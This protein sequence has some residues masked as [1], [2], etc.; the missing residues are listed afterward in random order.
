ML[1]S[2]ILGQEKAKK[3]LK[4]VMAREKMPHAYLFT[5]IPGIGKTSMALALALAL[6]C[7]TPVNG[8]GCGQCIPCRQML[9][10]NFPDFLSIKPE[11]QHIK[12]DQIR[13]LNRS[14]GFP[15]VSGGYRMCVIYQ[16]ETMTIEAANSFLKTLE[17]P[18]PGNILILNA[19][20]PLGLLPTIVSRCQ[21]V[22]FQPLPVQDITDWLVKERDLNEETAQVLAR[23][24]AGSLGRALKMCDSGFFDKREEWLARVI[25]LPALSRDEALEMALECAGEN[26][27][28]DIDT[29]ESGEAGIMDMLAIWESWYRDLLFVRVGGSR[30]LLINVDFSRKLKNIAG[31]FKINGLVDSLLMVDQAQRDLRRMRNTTLVME[32]TVLGLNRLAGD[33]K[34]VALSAAH[35]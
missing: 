14:L 31:S 19:P 7:S 17:E 15:P 16:A 23:V 3:F 4:K 29:S 30:H 20:A 9:G 18:P 11:G 21:R 2:Q 6:N 28:T 5:G 10:G 13:D 24:S 22:P 35:G 12:I 1:F 34:D 27:K 33:E 8:E 26:K 25:K 32:H